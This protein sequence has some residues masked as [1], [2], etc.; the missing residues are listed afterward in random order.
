M[1]TVKML[2]ILQGG[3]CFMFHYRDKWWYSTIFICALAMLS[4]IIVPAIAAIVLLVIQMKK[5]GEFYSLVKS[6]E[7]LNM[8][9]REKE[10][11]MSDLTI[12]MDIKETQLTLDNKEELIDKIK[13]D[14]IALIKTENEAVIEQAKLEA[15]SIVKEANENLQTMVEKTLEYSNNIAEST[16]EYK[17][18]V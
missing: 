17:K 12:N 1:I 7:L 10:E 3:R 14:T 11:L 5:R 18:L 15:E 8:P 2:F 16:E 6:D 4:F 13:N 9:I